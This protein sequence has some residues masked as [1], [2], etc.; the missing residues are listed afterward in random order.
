MVEMF[1]F[2]FYSIENFYHTLYW[3]CFMSSIDLNTC[4]FIAYKGKI[5]KMQNKGKSTFSFILTSLLLTI[6]NAFKW[7]FMKDMA[8]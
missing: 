4:T 5:T 2:I 6:E 8:V 1:Y 3:H 7:H